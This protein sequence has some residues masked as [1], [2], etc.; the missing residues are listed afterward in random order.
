[1]KKLILSAFVALTAMGAVAQQTEIF[2]K[3][4][5]VSWGADKAFDNTAAYT[6]VGAA[7]ADADAVALLAK[8]FSTEGGAISLTI[9][10]R[11]DAAV[12][13]YESSI[14]AKSEGYYLSVSA[15][16][17]VIAGHDAMGTY[18]GV[19][20]Y[21][22]VAAS[23]EV[24]S[25]TITDWPDVADRGLVEGYYGNPYSDADRK[26]LLEFFGRTKMNVY[27][28]GPKDDPYHRDRWR[29]A[30]P[31]A[32]A[33][34]ISELAATAAQ[35]KVR[36]VWALH[37]GGDIQWT[38]ADRKASVN[39][40][41]LMYDLGVRAFA[42]FFDDINGTEQ[43]KG[44]KQA[45]YLNYLNDNFV[46]KHADV[47]PIIMCPTEY[48]KAYVG[49]GSYLT[50]LGNTLAPEMHIMWTGNSVVDMIDKADMEWINSRINRNAYIWL[51]YP[52]N[53]Y[54]RDYLL[55]GP[56]YGNDLNIASML[57]GFTSN[58]MEYAESSKVSLY[59]IG[60]YCWNMASYDA[61]ASW[62]SAIKYLM[63]EES[64]AFHLFCENNVDLGN[65]VHGLRRT[66]ESP[67][68]VEAKTAF[69]NLMKQGH[70]A[71]AVAGIRDHFA[72]MADAATTLMASDHNLALTTEITPWCKV[73]NYMALKGLE[74]MKMY[75]AL[76][77]EQP[78]AFVES[79]LK[80]Q[81]YD[82]AQSAVRS[83]D[84]EGSIRVAH[85]AVA[86]YHVAPFLKETLATLI[87]LYKASYDY[88]LDVFPAQ[89]LENGTYYIMYDGK[90]LTNQSE[91]VD[92]TAPSFVDK[93]DDVKPQRQEWYIAI[94]PETERYKII[95]KQD[96][97]YLNEKGEFTVNNS[98][99]PYEAVW[100]TY[101]ILRMANGKYCIQNAGSAGNNFWTVSSSR[102]VKGGS[103]SLEPAN[104]IFDLVPVNGE[105]VKAPITST[106]DVYY[107]MDG[108]RYLTN[109]NPGSKGG[110]PTFQSVETPGEAQEWCFTIDPNGKNHYK[111]ASR[112][113]GR[114]VNEYAVFGTNDYYA[115][116][117]TYLILTMDGMCSI[118]VTQ[119]S[120]EAFHGERWWNVKGDI[121][122]IDESLTRSSSYVIKIVP[123]GEFVGPD[124]DPGVLKIYTENGSI[125]GT[126]N[127]ALPAKVTPLQAFDVVL[128]GAPG[129][130]S[131]GLTVRYGH[132]LDGEQYDAEGNQQWA[133]EYIT[134][135]SGK[136]TIAESMTEGDINLYATFE[137]EAGSE[138]ELVFSDEFNA[139]DYS[140]PESEKW[141]RCQRQGATW[142]RWLSDSE[143][144]IYLEDGDLVARAIPNP[145]KASDPVDM[146]TGG[147]KSMGRF[148]F[149]YGYVEARIYN[150]LWTGNFPAFWMMPE[151][152]SAGWPDCGEIDIWEAIDTQNTSYHT[153]HSNWT[154]DLGNTGNP[155]SSFNTSCTYDRYH[156]YG[157]AWD[158]TSLIWNLDG[159]EVGRYTKS[160]NSSHL[161]QG[162]WPFDK[163]FHL[164]LN[165]SVGNGSWAANADITH[166]YET[167]F[168]WVRVYQKVGM[169]N[170]NGVVESIND[171]E[172]DTTDNPSIYT[173]QGIRLNT[174]EEHLPKGLYIVGNKKMYVK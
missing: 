155:K 127:T 1:M 157:L 129:Y 102:V 10:E 67:R 91:G 159:K 149:T 173:L 66:N 59:S 26:S 32:E 69:N 29:E 23:P 147:I 99:N 76:E 54:C 114:Y 134:A 168:D 111:I 22:Q 15:D 88:R 53:D 132:N 21:L 79:Y 150:N 171:I 84:F 50:A 95:N 72:L 110:T 145:D 64:E 4:H 39:K 51:N 104:F 56:T 70:T 160:S 135:Q 128:R 83:R 138:W 120:Q 36:F 47:A 49:D 61:D 30:Y 174:S 131:K 106:R 73:M 62:E 137:R 46:K 100:H 92:G 89:E 74:L 7:D 41:E 153:I 152:Q 52:V 97:R 55:M 35:H 136:A 65:N 113:D 133:E 19:Q 117:N 5:Q 12:A 94:D 169:T 34:R 139:E 8:H 156:T 25:V 96:E 63:P 11:G 87:G 13:D 44:D 101:H 14:P 119:K 82:A 28:Y 105:A 124:P 80:Y 118:Q 123:K 81:E 167:R 90:Y 58:P 121:L 164:I 2:P 109:T 166:T 71:E 57:G 9:G 33:K 20:T 77:A 31:A 122:E 3:P 45:Q 165:Q 144:V 6:L 103:T 130:A 143:E 116:W 163:H 75:D 125:D 151:D 154:Y 85:P 146:I 86:T 43:R 60:D 42:I 142:N 107:I 27:I 162:Q 24:Q 38:D 170:T 126:N 108:D 140:Q 17:V 112:A 115:D 148:G 98:T 161:S 78:E 16:G 40:L 93:R 48:N 18:Y 141:M 68:F 158:E 172:L 37:P